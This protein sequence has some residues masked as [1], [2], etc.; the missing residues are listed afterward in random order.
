MIE[1]VTLESLKNRSKS[2]KYHTMTCAAAQQ[3]SERMIRARF[4]CNSSPSPGEPEPGVS[5]GRTGQ[6]RRCRYRR[7]RCCHRTAQPCGRGRLLGCFCRTLCD[8]QCPPSPCLATQ[9]ETP[10]KCNTFEGAAAVRSAWMIRNG[11]YYTHCGT[12]QWTE[13]LSF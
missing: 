4:L 11:A 9:R 7:C 12:L 13:D 8:Q 2:Y 5:G 6:W 10:V 1:C 3:Q